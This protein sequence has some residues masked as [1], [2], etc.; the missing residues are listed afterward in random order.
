MPDACFAL[1]RRPFCDAPDWTVLNDASARA[2]LADEPTR[3]TLTDEPDRTVHDCPPL[4]GIS[5][6]VTSPPATS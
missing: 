1:V 2:T 3:A 4:A 5:F 6:R